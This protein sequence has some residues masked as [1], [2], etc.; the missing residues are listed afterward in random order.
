MNFQDTMKQIG[1]W[2][3][4][5]KFFPSEV[6]ARIG[7]AE[8]IA[9]LAH[10]EEQ[11]RWLVLRVPKLYQEWPGMREVRAVFCSKF[12]PRDGVEVYSDVFLDGIPSETIATAA[13]IAPAAPL[14]Q[15][16]ASGTET[17][18]PSDDPEMAELA[19]R[20]KAAHV[21]HLP[22]A[23]VETVIRPGEG[24]LAAL[25]R[26]V[27][28]WNTAHERRRAYVRPVTDAEIAAVL[29][30]Q[31]RNRKVPIH[32]APPV[33]NM[34]LCGQHGNQACECPAHLIV[35]GCMDRELE[36]ALEIESKEML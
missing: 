5:L 19:R 36:S 20:V 8:Q 7:I 26:S 11:V 27:E 28:G 35:L 12:S 21:T 3:G 17:E 18:L 31:N 23:K 30:E 10:S 9:E 16:A 4:T 22:A 15:I 14:R 32:P 25:M 24:E 33:P 2:A 13:Q 34:D 1:R 6:E 29:E